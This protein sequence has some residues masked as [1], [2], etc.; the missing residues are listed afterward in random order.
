MDCVLRLYAFSGEAS[1]R[2]LSLPYAMHDN[3]HYVK[4]AQT[5]QLDVI[6]QKT[7]HIKT[8]ELLSPLEFGQLDQEG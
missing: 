3:V 8:L 1:S 4:P 6:R 5:S 2:G 7:E